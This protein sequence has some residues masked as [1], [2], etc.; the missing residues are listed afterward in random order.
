[1]PLRDTKN[2]MKRA[3]AILMALILIMGTVPVNIIAEGYPTDGGTGYEYAYAPSP[4]AEGEHSDTPDDT[5][6][7]D[8]VGTPDYNYDYVPEDEDYEADDYDQDTQIDLNFPQG[9]DNHYPF[10]PPATD[11]PQDWQNYDYDQ[12]TFFP[13]VTDIHYILHM[14]DGFIYFGSATC[15]DSLNFEPQLIE[16]ATVWEVVVHHFDKDYWQ[17]HERFNE[18]ELRFRCFYVPQ[19]LR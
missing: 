19:I 7:Y 11:S 17:A 14:Q 10:F 18:K 15:W 4:E 8:T 12:H 2:R 6:A 1:I 13:L 3:V 5:Y 16:L 9:E